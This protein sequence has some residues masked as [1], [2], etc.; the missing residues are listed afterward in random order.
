MLSEEERYQAEELLSCL[1]LLYDSP[2]SILSITEEVSPFR[3]ELRRN[4][5]IDFTFPATGLAGREVEVSGEQ[6]PLLVPAL[7]PRKGHLVTLDNIRSDDGTELSRL[8]HDRHVA[9]SRLMLTERLD[10]G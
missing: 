5:S 2:R 4:V 7:T 9:I 8:P 6:Q 1:T 3:A 10:S